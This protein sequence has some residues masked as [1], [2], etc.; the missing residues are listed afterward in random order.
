MTRLELESIWI[1]LH[2]K[3]NFSF[4]KSIFDII[5]VIGGYDGKNALNSV[6]RFDPREGINCTQVKSMKLERHFAAA[7]E[8]K[9][10]IYVTG[11]R[12]GDH[13]IDAVEMFGFFN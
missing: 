3:I 4:W 12:N 6:E 13:E 10:L 1:K 8:H 5:L 9:G 2:F 11:G 7:A